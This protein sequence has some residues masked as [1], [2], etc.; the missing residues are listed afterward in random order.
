MPDNAVLK[1][2]DEF[3]ETVNLRLGI[4]KKIWIFFIVSHFFLGI[5]GVVCSSIAA[6]NLFEAPAPQYLSLVSALCIAVIGFMRPES[7]YRSFVRA[8][9]ELKAAKDKYLYRTESR[10]ELLRVLHES[11]KVATED[12]VGAKSEIALIKKAEELKVT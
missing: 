10:D 4:W 8:W 5:I 12:E 2:E 1:S 7:R 3:L 6:S 11:E 9:R